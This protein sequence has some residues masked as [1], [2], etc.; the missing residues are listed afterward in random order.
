M[1]VGSKDETGDNQLCQLRKV[2][3][4]QYDLKMRILDR[5]RSKG[6]RKYLTIGNLDFN[7]DRVALAEALDAN[8]TLTSR[9]HWEGQHWR[10]FVS[11]DHAPARRVTLDVQHG[12]VGGGFNVD[13]LAVA[14]TDP[15][16]HLLRTKRFALLREDATSGHREAVLSDALSAAVGWA[17]DELKPLIAEELDFAAKK[18]A[19]RSSARKEHGCFLGFAMQNTGNCSKRSASAQVSN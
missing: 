17:K 6:E 10:A 13:H 14:E 9:L 2:A 16:G 7:Q 4:G 3:G 12:A 1:F 18:K 15:F 11:F 5:L 19:W 8:V